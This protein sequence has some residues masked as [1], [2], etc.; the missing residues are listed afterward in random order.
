MKNGGKK[1]TTA[2]SVIILY[3]INACASVPI[4]GSRILITGSAKRT[5]TNTNSVYKQPDLALGS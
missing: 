3:L 1:F 5:A 4:T 2:A